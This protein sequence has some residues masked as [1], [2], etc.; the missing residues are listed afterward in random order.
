MKPNIS[1][2]VAAAAFV[3]NLTVAL[4]RDVTLT[5][6]GAGLTEVSIGTNETAIVASWFPMGGFDYTRLDIIKDGLTV[7]FYSSSGF[8]TAGS[9]PP[10]IAGPATIRLHAA[11]G[12]SPR[13]FCTVQI[14]P[15]TFP[16]DK[17]VVIPAGVGGANIILE[18]STDLIH[19]TASTPGA[20]TNQESHLFFRIRAERLP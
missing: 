16:P 17:T 13:G 20:Y 1:V 7:S 19:W 18:R 4:A 9:S 8:S 14:E 2:F 11:G 15:A 5:V 12:T 6:G 10:R 3:L